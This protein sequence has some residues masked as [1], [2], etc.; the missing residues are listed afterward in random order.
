MF[1]LAIAV[2]S[3][4]GQAV[5]CLADQRARVPVRNSF[6]QLERKVGA[7]VDNPADVAGEG[8]GRED[9]GAECRVRASASH[10]VF[11][12]WLGRRVLDVI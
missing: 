4:R 1:V 2:P 9:A 12:R 5:R 10:Y 7:A 3:A 6:P 11:H 8:L